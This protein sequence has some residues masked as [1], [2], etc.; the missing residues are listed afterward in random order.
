MVY[1]A[2]SA[3]RHIGAVRDHHEDSLVAGP[4]TLCATVTESPQTLVF[5]LGPP[6]V[7]AVADGLGGHLGGEV[8][9]ALVVR[10][11]AQIGPMLDSEDRSGRRS[12]HATVRCTRRPRDPAL[13]AMGTTVAGV[14]VT[15]DL[16]LVFAVGD[17]RM[18]SDRSR[19]RAPA[20][21]RRPAGR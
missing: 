10:R 17:S 18:V 11:P 9:S 21:H 16:V 5:P 19:R 14:V 2:V 13:T 7:V 4:W 15:A 8:A 12:A 3:L 6:L 20:E 1:I